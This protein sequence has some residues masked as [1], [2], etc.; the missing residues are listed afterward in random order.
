M[1]QILDMT[2]FEL[3]RVT[4]GLVSSVVFAGSCTSTLDPLQQFAA[5][6]RAVDQ[7]VGRHPTEWAV[8]PRSERTLYRPEFSTSCSQGGKNNLVTL[9]Y[10]SADTE[11]DLYFT[12][13]L[14]PT[15]GV[16]E[17]RASFAFAVLTELPHG[18]DVPGWRFTLYTPTSHVR[19]GVT[20]EAAGN[21]VRI[22]IDTPLYAIGGISLHPS[23][24]PPAD[25]PT[26]PGCY[27]HREHGIPLRVTLQALLDG[28][29]LE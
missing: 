14:G 8:S 7:W 13:P 5:A 10:E 21:G 15:A 11:I 1:R 22:R 4:I 16:D 17:L 3:S 18:I 27:V 24:Q 6:N 23:C 19:D 2:R 26:P 28:S 20:F 12:C 9:T 25:A 29:E